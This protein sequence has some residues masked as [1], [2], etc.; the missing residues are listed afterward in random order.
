ML[1]SLHNNKTTTT[2]FSSSNELIIRHSST[3]CSSFCLLYSQA[4]IRLKSYKK[5]RGKEARVSVFFMPDFLG[6]TCLLQHVLYVVLRI[7]AE[8]R[9]T[10]VEVG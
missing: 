1:I 9:Y 4:K 2:F 10:T 3:L 6:E 7:G 8:E 5:K